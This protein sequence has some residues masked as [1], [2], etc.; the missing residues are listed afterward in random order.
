MAESEISGVLFE[1]LRSRSAK[2]EDLI[3]LKIYFSGEATTVKTTKNLDFYASV[4]GIVVLKVAPTLG[5]LLEESDTVELLI[6]DPAIRLIKGT[7][8]HWKILYRGDTYLGYL[9]R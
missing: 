7:G 2:P 3:G 1:L 8:I 9:N 4:T 6:G 5:G